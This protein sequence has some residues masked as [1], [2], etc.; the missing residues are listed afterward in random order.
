[1]RTLW[2]AILLCSAFGA[3]AEEPFRYRQDPFFQA[4]PTI[5]FDVRK[6]R[7]KVTITGKIEA[8]PFTWTRGEEFL[9][10]ASVLGDPV[11]ASRSGVIFRSDTGR[12]FI[13]H[14]PDLDA[15]KM[16]WEILVKGEGCCV[17]RFAKVRAEWIYSARGEPGLLVHDISSESEGELV[18]AMVKSVK[19]CWIAP[20]GINMPVVLDFKIDRNG[21]VSTILVEKIPDHPLGRELARSAEQAVRDCAP[22]IMPGVLNRRIIAT[23]EPLMP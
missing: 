18:Q 9:K 10:A 20:N 23:F 4:D 14:L 12:L 1:M 15:A 17:G 13:L 2:K 8:A 16:Q 6:S 7:D 5:D 22:Y 3:A 19:K 11:K 21:W